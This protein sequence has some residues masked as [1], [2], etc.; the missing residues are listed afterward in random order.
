[1]FIQPLDE[2]FLGMV[3]PLMQA[4]SDQWIRHHQAAEEAREHAEEIRELLLVLRLGGAGAAGAL[5]RYDTEAAEQADDAFLCLK[6]FLHMEGLPGAGCLVLGD[7]QVVVIQIIALGAQ[8]GVAGDAAV[9]EVFG[10]E[11]PGPADSGVGLGEGA[12]R[13]DAVVHAQFVPHRAIDHRG[14]GEGIGGTEQRWCAGGR[15]GQQGGKIF[16]FAARH[17]GVNRHLPH[18]VFPGVVGACGH[19]SHDLVRGVAGAGE[20]LGHLVLSGDDDGQ[21]VGEAI[22]Q[23]VLL[24]VVGC[25][26]PKLVRAQ[27]AVYYAG[28]LFFRRQRTGEGI[29]DLGHHR[30]SL[31]RVIALYI[32]PNNLHRFTFHRVRRES[33]TGQRH[34]ALG[35]VHDGEIPEGNGYQRCGGDTELF[36]GDAVTHGRWRTGASMADGHDR[37]MAL[38]LDL[39]PQRRII[40][41]IRAGLALEDRVDRWHVLFEPKLHLLQQGPAAGKAGID[42]VNSLAVQAVKPGRHGD[43]LDGWR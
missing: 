43:Q 15:D 31:D 9:A 16:R 29:L 36:N 4:A 25:I 13:A 38:L 5:S 33:D 27:V 18:I 19:L 2:L 8:V 30:D 40:L 32:G 21:V 10:Q 42:Q 7:D 24:Q 6:A 22:V 26:R 39:L 12:Q 14:I 41:G 17:D 11:S 34:A 35:R 1:M 3:A 23:V 20:H 37:G 28:F